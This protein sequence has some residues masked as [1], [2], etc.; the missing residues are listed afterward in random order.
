MNKEKISKL[1]MQLRK[2]KKM[3]QQ[4]VADKLYVSDV[5]VS[6]WERAICLPDITMFEQIADLFDITVAELISGERVNN[7]NKIKKVDE[8]LVNNIK[9][10]RKINKKKN[11]IIITLILTIFLIV[12]GLL[13][14][15]FFKNY[16]KIISYSFKGETTNFRFTKGTTILSRKNNL[17]EIGGFTIKENSSLN[18]DD[19]SELE[20]KIFI[21]ETK[22]ASEKYDKNRVTNLSLLE[23]INSEVYFSE[24]PTYECIVANKKCGGT[25]VSLMNK[26]KFPNDIKIEINYCISEKCEKE[27]FDI[28]YNE[29]ASN[30]IID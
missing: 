13:A 12:F 22:W 26:N 2:E 9:Q 5:A 15:F 14:V 10:E 25:P 30:K 21:N 28:F 19:I 8:I 27:V 20:I 23:W 11:I 18:L 16:N 29:I 17:L 3:T 4:E 6:K 24:E 7:D 1:I